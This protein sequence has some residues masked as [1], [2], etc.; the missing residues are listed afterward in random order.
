MDALRSSDGATATF[1]KASG[2]SAQANLTEVL[3]GPL[4]TGG[5]F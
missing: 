3:T 2:D 5:G 4:R 1:A